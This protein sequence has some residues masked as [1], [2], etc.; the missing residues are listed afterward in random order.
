MFFYSWLIGW[1]LVLILFNYGPVDKFAPVDRIGFSLFILGIGILPLAAWLLFIP[2]MVL[3][4]SGAVLIVCVP[5]DEYYRERYELRSY[6]A[7]RRA[8]DLE[9][10]AS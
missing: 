3:M 4:F 6:E 9:K 10:D 2:S 5:T 1:F 8:R 7:A